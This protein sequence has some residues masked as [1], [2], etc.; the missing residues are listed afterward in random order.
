MK[1]STV[2]AL[3]FSGTARLGC[4]D[5][6][7]RLLAVIARPG[8]GTVGVIAA[9]AFTATATAAMA[10][11]GSIPFV[12]E[13][14]VYRSYQRAVTAFDGREQILLL[15]SDLRA[16][17]PTKVLEV[18]PF[19]SR[20]EVTRGNEELFQKAVQQIEGRLA[21]QPAVQAVTEAR[22]GDGR[23]SLPGAPDAVF[24]ERIEVSDTTVVRIVD[25]RQFIAWA[26]EYLRASGVDDPAIPVRL[27]FLVRD[28]LRDGF[29]WFVFNVIELG[30]ET[31]ARPS[32]Q[33]RFATPRLYYPLRILGAESGDTTIHLVLVSPR[34]VRMPDLRPVRAVLLHQPVGIDR[35]DLGYLDSGIAEFLGWQ[36]QQLRLWEIKGAL[37]T[38][39]RDVLTE[40]F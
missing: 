13:A 30:P 26:T 37:G 38:M 8:N 23:S 11:C 32:V 29:T 12:A 31:V 1:W 19:P 24:H 6:A 4:R 33:Y 20:P 28:Y 9:V 16:D 7:R 14:R 22:R 27:N 5:R 21:R 25:P 36:R 35:D 10:N 15:S 39:R 2:V 3:P 34:L 18:L 40:W 17:R